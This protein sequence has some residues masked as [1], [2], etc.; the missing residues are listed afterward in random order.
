MPYEW[1]RQSGLSDLAVKLII[2][3][4]SVQLMERGMEELHRIH[5]ET[6]WG[7]VAVLTDWRR[8]RTRPRIRSSR[9]RVI[10]TVR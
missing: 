5:K 6:A 4:S 3:L 9:A 1:N 8:S 10:P 2:Q 7:W